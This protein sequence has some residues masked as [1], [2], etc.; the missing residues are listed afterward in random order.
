MAHKQ[1]RPLSLSLRVMLFVMLAIGLSLL[2]MSRLVLSTVERH[3]VEQDAD[4]L[5]VMVESIEHTLM[6]AGD[7]FSTLP[8]ILSSA[9][10]GHHGV[11]YEVRNPIGELLFRSS[12]LDFSSVTNGLTPDSVIDVNATYLWDIDNKTYRGVVAASEIEGAE[13]HIVSAIDMEFHKEFLDNFRDSLWLILLGAGGITLF[14]A[15][16]GVYQGLRPLRGVSDSVRAVQTNK[17]DTRLDVDAVPVEL[18]DLVHSFNQMIEQLELGFS[19]LSHFS[20]DIAHELRT[21]LTNMI[22]QTQV[23]LSKARS[24]T[25]YRELLYSVLEEQE[26]LTKMVNDMLWLAKTENGLVRLSNTPI[27]IGD[28]FLS[29]F[30]YFDAFAEE[31]QITLNVNTFNAVVQ[32][33]RE[34]LRRAFTNLISNAIAHASK[35]SAINITLSNDGAFSKVVVENSG[36]DIAAEHRARIFERFY[37]VDP[38]RQRNVE[39]AGLGLAIVKTVIEAHGGSIAVESANG[40]TR[41]IARLPKL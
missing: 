10:S 4:E 13:Y 37:R 1:P 28:E 3:F 40:K 9:G 32:G 41:F 35:Q 30:E 5:R 24:D 25:D 16:V 14:A 17:L 19:K 6:G 22:T 38:S 8:P 11:F 29:L 39:G 7:D 21:P 15:W 18:Q 20:D 36:Q 12:A 34:L 27:N 23:G 2:L 31:R 33:D 26:R